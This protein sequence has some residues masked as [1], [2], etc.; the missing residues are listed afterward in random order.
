MKLTLALALL[1]LLCAASQGE[2]HKPPFGV[3][4]IEV[5]PRSVTLSPEQGQVFTA[6]STDGESLT[7]CSWSTSWGEVPLEYLV[8]YAYIVTPGTNGTYYV[9]AN[10][11]TN[12]GGQYSAYATV[13]VD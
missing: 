1:T 6:S 7:A 8:V 12:L 10:C 11:T 13:M 4:G 5:T 2:S 3:P 9:Y